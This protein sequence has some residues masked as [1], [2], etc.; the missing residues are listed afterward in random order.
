MQYKKGKKIQNSLKSGMY[1]SV[2]KRPNDQ[3]EKSLEFTQKQKR[4]MR[5]NH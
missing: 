4:V 2:I 3:H 1:G 5:E